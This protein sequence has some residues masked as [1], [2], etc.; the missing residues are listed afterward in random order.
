VYDFGGPVESFD[1]AWGDLTGYRFSGVLTLVEGE[2]TLNDVQFFNPA[3]EGAPGPGG[4]IT[5]RL[6]SGRTRLDV[7]GRLIGFVLDAIDE[8]APGQMSSSRFN[9]RFVSGT[10]TGPFVAVLRTP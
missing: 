7:V 3:G 10:L 2:G 5:P 4:P 6:V 1:P 9:G 8:P